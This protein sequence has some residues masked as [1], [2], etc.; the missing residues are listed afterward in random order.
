MRARHI[1]V[2]YATQAGLIRKEGVPDTRLANSIGIGDDCLPAHKA[3]SKMQ[4]KKIPQ[5]IFTSKT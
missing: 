2:S 3:V 1:F 4:R 5:D